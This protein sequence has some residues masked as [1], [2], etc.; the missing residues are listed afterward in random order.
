MTIMMEEKEIFDRY[1]STH[2]ES[3]KEEIIMRYLPLVRYTMGRLGISAD[4]GPEYEDISS[5]GLLGLIDALDRYDGSYGTQFSTYATIKIRGKILDYLRSLDWL[6]RTARK[7]TK[8]VIEAMDNFWENNQRMP[9]DAELAETLKI[10]ISEVQGA[11][12]DSSRVMIS[13]DAVDHTEDEDSVSLHETLADPGQIDPA[14][15]LDEDES[16]QRLIEAIKTLPERHQ[17]LL[18]LYYYE[19][20]TFKE[21]G[22]V[23]G[24]SESRVCQIHGHATLAL[25]T[26]MSHTE[27][28]NQTENHNINTISPDS[29]IRKISSG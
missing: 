14:E 21:I 7:R 11:L 5:Q 16:K 10:D 3:L 9:T 28:I 19:N 1:L 22:E 6:S 24:I 13:F 2:D 4:S 20:L 23:L 29:I 17:L 8:V 27:S 26:I 18:S 15:I 12:I 25:K